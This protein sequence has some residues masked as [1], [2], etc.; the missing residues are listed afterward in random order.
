VVDAGGTRKF[1]GSEI[2][3][4][5]AVVVVA[6][7]S[8]PGCVAFGSGNVIVG[9]RSTISGGVGCVSVPFDGS[10][11]ILQLSLNIADRIAHQSAS[12]LRQIR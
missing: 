12:G 8:V 5:L 2:G 6:F 11:E 10:L 4:E 3:S 1:V 9:A 7:V